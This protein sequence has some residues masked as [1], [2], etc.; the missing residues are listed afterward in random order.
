MTFKQYEEG[1]MNCKYLTE[2]PKTPDMKFDCERIYEQTDSIKDMIHF[3]NLN[4]CE[5]CRYRTVKQS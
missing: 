2:Y 5:N 3:N 4:K 1:I